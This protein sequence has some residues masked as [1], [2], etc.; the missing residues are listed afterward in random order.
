VVQ[1]SFLPNN[2]KV[3]IIQL[4]R[5]VEAIRN[6]MQYDSE[7]SVDFEQQ[8]L[9]SAEPDKP[10]DFLEYDPGRFSYVMFP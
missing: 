2:Q 4:F 1:C 9:E 5:A 3:C 10:Q 7:E 6:F 8:V